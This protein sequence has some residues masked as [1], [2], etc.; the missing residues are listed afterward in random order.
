MYIHLH[1]GVKEMNICFLSWNANLVRRQ[2]F[3]QVIRIRE[4]IIKWKYVYLAI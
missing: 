3:K 4:V 1:M 2:T